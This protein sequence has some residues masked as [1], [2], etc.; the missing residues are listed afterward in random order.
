LVLVLL[1]AAWSRSGDFFVCKHSLS[2]SATRVASL[3][4]ELDVIDL[5]NCAAGETGTF[6]LVHDQSLQPASA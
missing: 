2:A 4:E 6:R 3:V 5:L 1:R